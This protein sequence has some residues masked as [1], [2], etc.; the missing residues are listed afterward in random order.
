MPNNKFLKVVNDLFKMPYYKNHA[1]ASGAVHNIAAHEDAVE[2]VFKKHGFTDSKKNIKELDDLGRTNGKVIRDA[3]MSGDLSG[4]SLK[5][6]EY[7]SQPL[8]THD[9]PDFILKSAGK[10]FFIECKSSKQSRPT[11]NGGFPK[12][13]YIYAFSSEKEDKT[14]VYLGRD[15]NGGHE[16]AKAITEYQEQINKIKKDLNRTLKEINLSTGI[17]YY[18]RDMW[19]HKGKKEVTN[20][21]NEPRRSQWFNNVKEFINE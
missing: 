13:D 8:G 1:A 16:A 5:D 6:G 12:S 18:V 4:C 20:Y 17:E 7:A 14:V 21:F 10:V 11:Y 3:W 19:N 15:V 2:D 9:S